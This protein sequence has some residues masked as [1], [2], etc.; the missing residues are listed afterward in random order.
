MTAFFPIVESQKVR[1]A[2][3][4]RVARSTTTGSTV[5]LS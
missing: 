3:R 1:A 5:G 4:L 2:E